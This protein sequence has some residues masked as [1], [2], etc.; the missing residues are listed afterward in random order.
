[1]LKYTEKIN[2]LL[3]LSFP[4][5]I[6]NLGVMLIGVGDVYV[7]AKYSTD[8]LASISI[9][10]SIFFTM[11]LIGLGILASISPLL[12]NFRGEKEKVKKYFI[13]TLNF[14]L[15]LSI[16][17][18]IL[19]ILC[20]PLI[21]ILGFEEKLIPDIKNYLTICSFSTIGIYAFIAAKEFLQA[22]EIVL[23]PNLLNMF[24]VVLNLAL[25]FILVFGWYK[26]PSMGCVGLAWA[27]I[28]T[29]FILAFILI[30][31]CF[32]KIRIIPIFNDFSYYKKLLKLGLPITAAMF[33]ETTAFNIIT[34]LIGRISG[35][36]AAAQ[37][38]II[39]LANASFM[40][41]L[42]V[43]NAISIKVG[44]TNGAKDYINLKK[45]LISGM[46]ISETHMAIC[47]IL[48]ITIPHLIIRFF[49]SDI[50]LIN[51][52]TP[53]MFIVGL[54]QLFDG[55][56]I[57]LSGAFKGIKS[58]TIVMFGDFIAYWI[59][60]IP[61][62]YYLA[63][64]RHLNLYGF[65]IGLAIALFTLGTSLSIIIYHKIKNLDYKPA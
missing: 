22:Y 12:S 37:T 1:M 31:Y 5:I 7:A 48:Y 27:S 36:Y 64:E 54:F 8:V 61:V 20:V 21:D 42:A 30:G 47:A 38:L 29:R 32:T 41:P 4:I 45:Y 2:E 14:S 60:G 63:F 53:I 33:C 10:N 35:I 52:C 51:I 44:Y 50:N 58:T 49:T 18:T 59:L 43:S 39:T 56:Q 6:G 15:Y 28:I 34:I 9:A 24:G 11:F 23:L 65:W 19:T 46:I 25:N 26:I 55:A 16:I 3:K 57:S 17:I 40:I 13:P 62:G